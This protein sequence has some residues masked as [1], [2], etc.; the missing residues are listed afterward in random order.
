VQAPA[1]DFS[2]DRRT[3]VA[4]GQGTQRVNTVLVQSPQP[5]NTPP[6]KQTP[7]Y[8]TAARLTY[9]DAERTA[10][11]EGGVTMRGADSTAT[12]DHAE[13]FLRPAGSGNSGASQVD[14]IVAEKDILIQ[15]PNR[16]ATGQKMVYAAAEDKFVLSGGS[17]SI[18]DAERGT[19]TGASLTFWN[20]NDRV[21]VEG[22][23]SRA[24]TQTRVSK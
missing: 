7:F 2:R 4:Q 8:V 19:I 17:P 1:I 3:I 21:L 18:F 16:K 5:A 11:F 20:R 9:S 10:R 24:V 12:A 23:S 13:V 14:R 22:G 6:G 15:Q